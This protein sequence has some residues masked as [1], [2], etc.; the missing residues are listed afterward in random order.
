M[1]EI[2]PLMWIVTAAFVVYF[3]QDWLLTFG[4]STPAV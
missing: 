3:L 4:A 1:A 2:H